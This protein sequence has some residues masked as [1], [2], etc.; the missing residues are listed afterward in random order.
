[1]LNV[2]D[3]YVTRNCIVVYEYYFRKIIA[4]YATLILFPRQSITVMFPVTIQ[5]VMNTQQEE[6]VPL[7][8]SPREVRSINLPN[9]RTK[10]NDI[11]ARP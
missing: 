4:I 6:P 11:Q 5:L 8:D 2:T 3:I 7:S 9:V 10:T 1:M